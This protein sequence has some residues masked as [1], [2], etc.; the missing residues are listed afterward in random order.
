MRHTFRTVCFSAVAS[1]LL[2]AAD[3]ST[4]ANR[5]GLIRTTTSL[6]RQPAVSAEA[7]TTSQE[8][9]SKA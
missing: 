8:R 7:R 2:P 4:F 9:S 5:G 3:P 1:F 6:E